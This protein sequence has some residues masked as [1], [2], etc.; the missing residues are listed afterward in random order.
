[1]KLTISLTAMCEAESL[2]TPI[3][4]FIRHAWPETVM[5]KNYSIRVKHKRLVK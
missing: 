4:H 5:H 1:M 2:S 3:S